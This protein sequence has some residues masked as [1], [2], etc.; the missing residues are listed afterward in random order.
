MT[1]STWAHLR[2]SFSIFLTPVFFYC[3]SDVPDVAW[4]RSITLFAVL[5]LGIFPASNG[6]NSFFDKDQASIGGLEKPPTVTADLYRWSLGLEMA[7]LAISAAV[8]GGA[9]TVLVFIYG[10]FS[11]LYSHPRFRW[12]ARPYL[13]FVTVIVLQGAWMYWICRLAL[14]KHPESL[15]VVWADPS[16]RARALVSSLLIAG[17]YPITQVYQHGEDARRGDLTFSRLLGVRGTF[18]FS[19]SCLGL[20][21]VWMGFLWDW[22]WP[23]AIFIGV[24]L[25][26]FVNF[27]VWMRAVWKNSASAEISA[28]HRFLRLS[29]MCT[30]FGL[31]LIFALKQDFVK[32]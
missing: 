8:L 26:A 3:L 29:S 18:L 32:L 9:V 22:K 5:T 2:F 6:Y 21:L 20:A 15:W 19:A 31:L 14:V 11:K 13:G 1:A 17:S 23:A 4:A 27:A 24:S 28:V 7:A 12:K 16:L 30:I 25:P 10:I